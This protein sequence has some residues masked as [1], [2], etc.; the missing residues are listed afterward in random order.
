MNNN[1]GFLVQLPDK[2]PLGPPVKGKP[3]V[4]NQ[5]SWEGFRWFDPVGCRVSPKACIS[6]RMKG[7]QEE[8]EA[9]ETH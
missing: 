4:H 7:T 9:F 8:D 5:E 6:R 3:C 2:V 1:S